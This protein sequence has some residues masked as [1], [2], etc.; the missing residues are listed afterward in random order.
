MCTNMF[1]PLALFDVPEYHK[2]EKQGE[3]KSK[4][5]KAGCEPMHER[6]RPEV[7]A[8]FK[9]TSVQSRFGIEAMQNKHFH[10]Q[11][12]LIHQE[13]SLRWNKLLSL[14]CISFRSFHLFSK[15]IA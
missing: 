12:S 10:I 13:P 11:I 2:K 4:V 3:H 7:H 15:Y 1:P 5:Q 9:Y 8:H 14:S 6:V